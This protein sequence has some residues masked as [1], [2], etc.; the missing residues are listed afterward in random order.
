MG[1]RGNE[2]LGRGGDAEGREGVC[3]SEWVNG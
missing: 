1:W 3:V 2:A